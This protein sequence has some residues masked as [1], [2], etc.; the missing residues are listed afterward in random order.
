MA[1]FTKNMIFQKVGL[2]FFDFQKTKLISN[3][4]TT[5]CREKYHQRLLK[6]RRFLG[7]LLLSTSR[8]ITNWCTLDK[9]DHET[10]LRNLG[11]L[12]DTSRKFL[13][14]HKTTVIVRNRTFYSNF[15]S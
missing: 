9:S 13:T 12:L 6:K 14:R 15:H 10:S 5:C 7:H 4:N 1:V 8:I 3:I 11:H 2:V